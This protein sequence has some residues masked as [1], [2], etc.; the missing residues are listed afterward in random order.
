M[1]VIHL[2]AIYAETLYRNMPA[3]SACKGMW[4]MTHAEK[5]TATCLQRPHKHAR[6]IQSCYVP[7]NMP[8]NR[9]CNMP[10]QSACT[11]MLHTYL[12]Q[13]SKHNCNMPIQSARTGMLQTE[14]LHTWPQ[15]PNCYMT[16]PAHPHA[17]CK[18]RHHTAKH[19]ANIYPNTAAQRACADKWYTCCGHRVVSENLQICRR[20]CS[21]PSSEV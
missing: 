1:H 19:V 14:L 9:N 7:G 8:T 3:Q 20:S 11:G 18:P 4:H 15:N 6:C 5:C 21:Y 12:P 17:H 2:A 10:V 13:T 16:T